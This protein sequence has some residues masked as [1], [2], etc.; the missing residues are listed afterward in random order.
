M[1][2]DLLCAFWALP[3]GKFCVRRRNMQAMTA[4][5]I[6]PDHEKPLS[7]GSRAA[8]IDCARGIAIVLVVYR[9]VLLGMKEAGL[10]RDVF[11]FN[12]SHFLN[13]TTA[14]PAFF[15]FAGFFVKR[16]CAHYGKKFMLNKLRVLVYPYFIWSIITIIIKSA[17]SGYVNRKAGF[18]DVVQIAYVPYDIF[19]FL[20]ILFLFEVIFWALKKI[21]TRILLAASVLLYLVNCF[22]SFY[23]TLDLLAQ[24]LPF[25]YLGAFVYEKFK[26]E[27]VMARMGIVAFTALAALLA[28]VAAAWLNCS[29]LESFVMFEQHKHIV[30]LLYDCTGILLVA[31]LSICIAGDKNRSLLSRLL[32][33]L[34]VNSLYIYVAHTIFTAGSRIILSKVFDIQSPGVH[35]AAGVILGVACSLLLYGLSKRFGFPYL[36]RLSDGDGRAAC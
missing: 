13:V 4:N 15:F 29:G 22:C 27:P 17:M 18:Q 3:P 33:F 14:L 36:Y 16:S 24:Y 35:V 34:G 7:P 21:D 8:W 20:Y 12:F 5:Q 28:Q 11:F 32:V 30:N 10:L 26:I 19:W 6:A 9:H 25:F 2:P 31:S 1:S 23:F